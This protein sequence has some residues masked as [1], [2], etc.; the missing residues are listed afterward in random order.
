[1]V[2]LLAGVRVIDITS[3]LFGPLATQILGDLGA[4]VIKV[5]GPDG[6]VVRPV[7][8]QAAP[9]L[10]PIFANVNRNKRSLCVDLKTDEGRR[11]LQALVRDADVLVH[12]MRAEA[13][14]RLG[15]GPEAARALNPRLIYC[16][17]LGFGSD[18]PYAGRPAYDDI[19][20]AASGLA[21]VHM[22]RDGEPTY[23]PSVTA[24][25]VGALHI[26]YAV[27][28]ALFHRERR[29]SADGPGDGAACKERL[30]GGG[31]YV[32][33]PMFEAVTAFAMNEHLMGATFKPDGGTGYH[34]TMTRNRR[35]YRTADGW[36]GVLAYTHAQWTRV[37]PVLGRADVLD[38]PWF[39][40]ATQRS[41]RSDELYGMLASA[42]PQKTT[43]AWLSL[44]RDIDIPVAPVNT[45]D[46]LLR[47]PHL[48]AVG[49]FQP[50]FDGETPV[51]RTLRQPVLYPEVEGARDRPPPLLGGH[52]RDVLREAGFEAEEIDTLIASGA[53]RSTD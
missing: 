14:D 4:D 41:A 48:D 7:P 33:V 51:T 12:N 5:E 2:P 29:A 19:V 10:G 23:A 24:D 31:T 53:V 44:L 47:D 22:V 16:A 46:D 42:L 27:M 18:G 40:D 21:G 36:L 17:A 32:E 8:P 43:Q 38:E 15:F 30:Q 11:V 45:P 35:P 25:K 39:A 6:D 34:R 37:L 20:Q 26:A 9:G 3:V 49:F 13:I 50:N 52:S 1:M 28:A